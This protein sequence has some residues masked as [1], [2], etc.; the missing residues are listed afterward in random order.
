LRTAAT[1]SSGST[2][3]TS[4]LIWADAII[5]SPFAMASAV[6]AVAL[7]RLMLNPSRPAMP[8]MRRL[9]G[10]VHPSGSDFPA[11]LGKVGERRADGLVGVNP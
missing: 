6:G 10:D 3:V 7:I 9:A 1:D 2:I 8:P 11:G 4:G 5:C